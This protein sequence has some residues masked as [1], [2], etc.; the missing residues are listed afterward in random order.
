MWIFLFIILFITIV[1][2]IILCNHLYRELG[3]DLS[4]VRNNFAESDKTSHEEGPWR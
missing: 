3:T 4:L 1:N 2:I